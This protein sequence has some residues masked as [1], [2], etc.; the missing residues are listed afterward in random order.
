MRRGRRFGIDV[1]HVRVGV[2][3]CDPDGLVATPVTTLRRGEED[4]AEV[5]RLVEESGAIEVIVGLPLHM[6]GTEGDSA[7]YAREWA[8]ALAHKVDVP[9]RMVDERLSTVSAHAQLRAAGRDTRTHRS[10]VDQAAAMVILE[11]ALETERR[12]GHAAGELVDTG[13][14]S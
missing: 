8:T 5:A 6:N 14:N 11:T 4:V 10:V 12:T 7:H 2:A 13:R 3:T 1:G 9:I